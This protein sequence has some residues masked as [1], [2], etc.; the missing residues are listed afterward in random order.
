MDIV[1][2]LRSNAASLYTEGKFKDA[3]N[4]Y[5]RA[6]NAALVT[7]ANGVTWAGEDVTAKPDTTSDLFR[8]T[9][10]CLTRAEEIVKSRHLFTV[11]SSTAPPLSSASVAQSAHSPQSI[12]FPER[13]PLIPISPLTNQHALH[14]YQLSVAERRYAAA[15]SAEDQPALSTMRRLVEDVRIQ[16]AKVQELQKLADSVATPPMISWKAEAVALQIA[17]IDVSLFSKIRV[18]DD[19]W[20]RESEIGLNGRACVDFNKYLER[21]AIDAILS[22]KPTGATHDGPTAR[23]DTIAFLVSVAHTLFYHYRDINGMC[24]ILQALESPEIRR[25]RRTWD[26]IHAKTKEAL[27]NLQSAIGAGTGNDH[28]D[29][30][31]QVLEHHYCGGGVLVAI[32]YLEPFIHDMQDLRNA[33]SA[34]VSGSTGEAMMSD[35]G[36][37]ALEEIFSI[38]ELC[39]GVGR[40]DPG[41]G[42]VGR[43]A[44]GAASRSREN[45]AGNGLP[46]DLSSL[47]TGNQGLAHWLLT[48]VYWSRVELWGK[49]GDNERFR[50]DEQIPDAY[51]EV[52]AA[53]DTW[54]NDAQVNSAASATPSREPFSKSTV[55]VPEGNQRT[56][57]AVSD[58]GGSSNQEFGE[59]KQN[60]DYMDQFL[61]D[62]DTPPAD[63]QQNE[64]SNILALLDELPSVPHL[65]DFERASEEAGEDN[66]H[67]QEEDDGQFQ[68]DASNSNVGAPDNALDEAAP[69]D[70][71]PPTGSDSLLSPDSSNQVGDAGTGTDDS[72]VLAKQGEGF[73]YMD[74]YLGPLDEPYPGSNMELP[75]VESQTAVEDQNTSTEALAPTSSPQPGDAQSTTPSRPPEASPVIEPSQS[76]A[77]ISMEQDPDYDGYGLSD[78]EVDAGDYLDEVIAN[79]PP[80]YE[81]HGIPSEG[82]EQEKLESTNLAANDDAL[83]QRFDSLR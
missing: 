24:A 16:R 5:L 8:L 71:A 47:G 72:P 57:T 56:E 22:S 79:T 45:K 52:I 12:P 46:E 32:P 78:L 27:R 20:H 21:I 60:S 36:A 73:D 43:A 19:L 63:V 13:V 66:A 41:L 6:A 40:P 30:V 14:A 1:D 77:A 35:I 83:R 70:A 23:A 3:Y 44:A 64:Q 54:R 51:K 65:L 18:R 4:T 49:S 33:Y 37:R 42:K 81:K 9:Q 82:S 38:I 2:S 67:T 15:T 34:G 26:A 10:Q 29:L 80:L 74:R 7:L 11:R 68:R 59:A 75:E 48:R 76:I 50:R 25:L 53:E 28:L 17:I 58:P 61:G 62:V 39:Q 69:G 31:A 55:S